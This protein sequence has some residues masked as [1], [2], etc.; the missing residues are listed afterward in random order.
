MVPEFEKPTKKKPLTKMEYDDF[1]A[2][3]A[4]VTGDLT[5]TRAKLW[6]T[7]DQLQASKEKVEKLEAHIAELV[8]GREEDTKTIKGLQNENSRCLEEESKIRESLDLMKKV[9]TRTQLKSKEE[10]ETITLLQEER[11]LL[12]EENQKIRNELFTKSNKSEKSAEETRM[13]A[14]VLASSLEETRAELAEYKRKLL[15]AENTIN[16]LEQKVSEAADS[17]ENEERMQ[18]QRNHID[19]LENQ[20][21]EFM[22]GEVRGERN[23]YDDSDTDVVGRALIDEDLDDG[24]ARRLMQRLDCTSFNDNMLQKRLDCASFNDDLAANAYPYLG[25]GKLPHGSL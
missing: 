18:N 15:N 23:F 17:K 14:S 11:D 7:Q 6:S 12:L 8:A 4:S 24:L 20:L 13:N 16:T 10:Q 1:M 22:E 9:F 21:M 19:R 3:I 2:E 25:F 5:Q